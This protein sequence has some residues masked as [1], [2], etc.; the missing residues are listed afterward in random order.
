MKYG[1]VTLGQVE[2]AINILGG[3]ENWLKL[4]AGELVV[5]TASI[6][7][8][9][10]TITVPGA[11]KFVAKDMFGP[12]NS[13]SIKFY[14]GDGF[15]NHF[16]GL[17]EE[18]VGPVE[19]AVHLLEKDSLDQEIVAELGAEKRVIKLTH[20]YNLIKAQANS[21]QDI[22]LVNGWA[23]IAYIQDNEGVFWAVDANWDLFYREWYVDALSVE[24]PRAWNAGNRF[25]SQV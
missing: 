25:L 9:V 16:L 4:L 24:D 20:F 5:K 23:N 6:L 11:I 1:E 12:D 15:K 17:T 18:N 22:L 13:D 10:A 14:L 21:Q 2:A 19:I 8:L 7:K 3:M